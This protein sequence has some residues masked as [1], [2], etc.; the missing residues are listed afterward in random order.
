MLHLC[1]RFRSINTYIDLL[2]IR[3]SHGVHPL[4]SMGSSRAR[5]TAANATRA[6]RSMHQCTR[7]TR[8]PRIP[9]STERF[10]GCANST[11]PVCIPH[12]P[13][14]DRCPFGGAC[15]KGRHEREWRLKEMEGMRVFE[16]GPSGR[17]HSSAE[18]ISPSALRG[19]IREGSKRSP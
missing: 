13:L 8:P 4:Y 7:D 16:P 9:Q 5:A 11:R 1:H 14:R 3:L 15:T 18:K 10:L 19:S 2:K 17:A 6:S 12:S